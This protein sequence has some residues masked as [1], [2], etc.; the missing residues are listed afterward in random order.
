MAEAGMP[1]NELGFNDQTIRS[2]FVR[3]VFTIVSIMLGVVTI[4]SAIP[5]FYTETIMEAGQPK[6]TYP[7]RDYIKTHMGL[8]IL[9]M[10]VFFVVYLVLLCCDGVRRAHPTNLICTGILTLA[11]GFMTATITSMYTVDSVV[12]ALAVTTLS[13]V[14]IIIFS[15]TTKRD[16]TSLMGFMFIATLCLMLFGFFAIFW[17]MIFKTRMLY[18]VY[19]GLG[20]LLF[21]VYLAI[22]IQ[23]IMGGRKYEISP[24][25]HIFAAI[26]LFMDIVQIFWFILSLLGDRS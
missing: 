16:I 14:G 17:T 20:T 5:H 24:E 7:I 10:V 1:K 13:C 19:A 18:M 23:M 9:A 25:E 22:D 4:M 11:I 8:Y 6:V 2:A 15:M 26:M 12:L 21:M 3:K